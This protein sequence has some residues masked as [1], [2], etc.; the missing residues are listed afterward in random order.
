M[1]NHTHPHTHTYFLGGTCP[2]LT[3]T[4][5]TF[6]VWIPVEQEPRPAGRT[7]AEVLML[8]VEG[9]SVHWPQE[10]VCQWYTVQACSLQL[11]T[12]CRALLL[13]HRT[14]PAGTRVKDT[15]SDEANDPL[16]TLTSDW[17]RAW[18]Q[19]FVID[20]CAYAKK[21]SVKNTD[22]SNSF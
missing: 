21:W 14:P 22:K 18:M 3:R 8:E 10:P 13:G 19:Y 1:M 15:V 11:R 17:P 16:I 6:R 20:V 9:S 12:S 2:T 5:I 4:Q 7:A